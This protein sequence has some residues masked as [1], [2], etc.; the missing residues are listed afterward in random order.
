MLSYNLTYLQ[1][2]TPEGQYI[3]ALEPNM[4]EVV[5]FPTLPP[6]RQL[7]YQAKQMIAREIELEKMRRAEAMLQARNPQRE[8]EKGQGGK[9]VPPQGPAPKEGI[10]NHQ[11]RLESIVKQ[12]A[13][14]TAKPEVDFF[15]RA[16][17][18][19]EK[20][21]STTATAEPGKGAAE[22]RIGKAVGSSDVWFRF[23]EGVSNAVRRNVYI[24]DLL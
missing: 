22:P 5:R 8:E 20:L 24:K 16:I 19:K 21:V 14:E 11:Q 17:T 6:R 4:E 10:K 9:R 12:A 15:G 7:T 13:V 1:S 23:N 3:Y 2:R 18:I